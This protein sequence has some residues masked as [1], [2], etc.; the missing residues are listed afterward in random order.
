MKISILALHL[1]YGGIER[2]VSTLANILIKQYDEVEIAC[3]Y[4]LLDEP[5]FHI[6]KK[7]NIK[8]LTDVRPNEAEFRRYVRKHRY[9][10]AFREGLYSLRVLSLKK[11]AMINYI[12]NC[13]SDV[14]IATRDILD[15]WLGTYGRDD[16]I[17]IG[18]EHN[19]YHDNM[20]YADKVKFSC[21]NLDYLVLV[22]KSLEAFYKGMMRGTKCECL[23]IPNIIE[24]MPSKNDL[25]LLESKRLVSVGRLSP[26]KGYL[27]LLKIFN[28]IS[29]DYPDWHLDIIG[30]GPSREIL[31][32][33]IKNN[34]LEEKVTLHVFQYKKY[35]YQVMKDSSIYLMTSYTESFG[36]VLLEAMSCGLPCI[37]FSSAEGANEIIHSGSNGYLIKNRNFSAYIK[38]CEDLMDDFDARKKIGLEGYRTV[39]KYRPSTVSKEWFRLIEKK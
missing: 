14:I 15:E 1:N 32:K 21:S 19:H 6:S 35:I 30:D 2:C 13:D 37:S 4:K 26:E 7:V 34:D 10:K 5:A 20:K 24:D 17:K 3:I 8:Y 22:S 36:I 11:K 28:I 12:K 38:K 29:H 25:S 18:W 31:E 16:V 27:D 39:A 23:Y 33:Y 9:I